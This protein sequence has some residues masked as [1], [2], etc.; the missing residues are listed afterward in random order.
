MTQAGSPNPRNDRICITSSCPRQFG[1][2]FLPLPLL[3]RQQSRLLEALSA[4]HHGP[5]HTCDLVGQRDSSDLDRP[6]FHNTR[7]PK[8]LRA[9]LPRISDDRHGAGDEQPSQ[10]SIALL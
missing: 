3:C 1:V 6:A 7:K 9:V 4:H 5:G 8:P 10:I 2:A